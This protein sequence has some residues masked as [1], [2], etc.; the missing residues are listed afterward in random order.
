MSNTAVILGAICAG[1][2]VLMFVGVLER[3]ARAGERQAAALER[4]VGHQDRAAAAMDEEL[5]RLT[6]IDAGGK[7]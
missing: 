2:T 1:A 5:H 6:N 7:P 3:I 4:L